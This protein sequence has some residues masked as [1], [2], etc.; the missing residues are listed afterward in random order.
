MNKRIKKR[1]IEALRSGEYKKGKETLQPTKNTYCC[2]GVLTCLYNKSKASKE[3]GKIDPTDYNVLPD[4]VE[5]W[6]GLDMDDPKVTILVKNKEVKTSL[7]ALNDGDGHR[8]RSFKEIADI[9]EE[10]L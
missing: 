4:R 5:E 9:I 3:F 1:W 10:Q 8:A 7:A 6:A 2:L